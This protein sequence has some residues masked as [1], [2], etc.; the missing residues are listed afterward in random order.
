MI[1]AFNPSTYKFTDHGKNYGYFTIKLNSDG[2]CSGGSGGGGIG[3]LSNV[4]VIH[5]WVMW[6]TWTIIG[7][8]QIITARYLKHWWQFSECMHITLGLLCGA[9]SLFGSLIM[10]KHLS[11]TFY[12]SD[13]RHNL[14]GTIF[15]VVGL[16]LVIGGVLA[17]LKKRFSGPW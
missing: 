9:L 6:A 10:L 14:F 12:F 17:W 13:Q 2:S 8:L 15:S 4:G 7:L 3:G 11:F 5:G 16:L 1:Y